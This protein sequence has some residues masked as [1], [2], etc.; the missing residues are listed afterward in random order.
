M[1]RRNE[2]RRPV[3]LPPMARTPRGENPAMRAWYD[4]RLNLNQPRKE[5]RK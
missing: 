3:V 5:D 1:N 2:K 4:A